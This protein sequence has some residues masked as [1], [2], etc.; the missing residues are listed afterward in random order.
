MTL[1]LLLILLVFPL[2]N[3]FSADAPL[4]RIAQVTAVNSRMISRNYPDA[5]PSLLKAVTNTTTLNIDPDPLFLQDFSDERIYTCP[6]V[7]MNAA[8]RKDWT[9][10]SAEKEVLKRYLDRGGFLF[11]DAGITASFL[12]GKSSLGQHHS[13]AEWEASPEIKTAFKSIF[14]ELNFRA[15]KRSDLLYSVFFQGLPDAELLPDTVK[16]YTIEEKWPD[17]TYSATALKIKDRIAVLATPIIAMGWGKN[18]LGQWKTNINFRVLQGNDGLD[19][20]LKSAAYNGPR[21]EVTREDHG[22]DIIFCQG[23]SMPAWIE[24]PGGIWRV[25]R[26]Y[27][28]REISDF[29]HAFYTRLGTNI[30]V[31]AFTH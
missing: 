13:Y 8:D 22:K 19:D 27:G 7:Y 2:W 6:F 31:Y 3:A 9:F 5:L 17:G 1:F 24:E 29:A 16:K 10:S 30:L 18:S 4:I 20:F 26:Y 23:N 14:P 11:I 21:Y 15:L 25:F 28:S 12:R